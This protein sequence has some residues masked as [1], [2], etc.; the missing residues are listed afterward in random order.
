[1]KAHPLVWV[2]FIVAAELIAFW[3]L[4]KS[5]DTP[6]H[7]ALYITLSILLFGLIVPLAFRQTLTSTQIAVSNMYW[8]ILSQIGSIVLGYLAFNQKISGRSMVAVV[9]LFLAVWVQLFN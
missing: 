4:Q 2:S 8:I 9:L 5:V 3:M 6:K 1:M 7:A